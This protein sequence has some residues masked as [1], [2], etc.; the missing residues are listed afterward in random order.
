M[1]TMSGPLTGFLL[2]HLVRVLET[3]PAMVA[4]EDHL[5]PFIHPRQVSP[6]GETPEPL[7]TCFALLRTWQGRCPRTD[8][9]L[10]ATY[11]EEAEIL[12]REV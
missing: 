10:R 1:V 4:Q 2:S 6:M 11:R 8:H 12:F 3:F 9:F 7:A 5:P